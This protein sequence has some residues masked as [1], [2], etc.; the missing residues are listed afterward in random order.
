MAAGPHLRDA[1]RL[2]LR[3]PVPGGARLIAG[4][5]GGR[6]ADAWGRRPSLQLPTP[7]KSLHM[8]S[9]L[10][11]RRRRQPHARGTGCTAARVSHRRLAVAAAAVAAAPL[12]SP[13]AR[14]LLARS[15]RRGG[16]TAYGLRCRLY[17]FGCCSLAAR[18]IGGAGR[19]CAEG[20]LCAPRRCG[21]RPVQAAGVGSKAAGATANAHQPPRPR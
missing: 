18:R 11:G 1:L 20:G 16:V 8:A 7:P 19:C 17:R 13:R 2:A 6:H 3:G 10:S 9:V 21:G 5:I 14:G 15:V 4:R 12:S